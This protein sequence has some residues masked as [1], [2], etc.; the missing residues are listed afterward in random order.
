MKK[1]ILLL[2]SA[3]LF[4][5]GHCLAEATAEAA[6]SGSVLSLL[7]SFWPVV[8]FLAAVVAVILVICQKKK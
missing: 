6:S 3:L 8:A 5:G 4:T 1:R 7:L 2:I